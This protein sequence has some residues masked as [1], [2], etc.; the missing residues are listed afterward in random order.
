MPVTRYRSIDDV[1]RP[2]PRPTPA[3]N[4]RVACE[5]SDLCFALA[6]ANGTTPDR[7]QGE[8]LPSG[9]VWRSE[10]PHVARRSDLT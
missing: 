6:K 4:L 1:L 9:R 7:A 2:A 8:A 10:G 3:E 5:L